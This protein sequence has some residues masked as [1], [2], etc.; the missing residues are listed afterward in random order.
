MKVRVSDYI[1]N[2]LAQ[3]KITQ[4]FTVVGGGSMYLN[5]SFG[6]H[7]ELHCLYNHHEQASAM[8]AEAY[9]RIA[10]VPGVVCVTS[11]PG[12]I[13]A[14]NG[15]AGAYQDSIPLLIFSGQ[16][17]TK[18]LANQSGLNL[19]TMGGQEFDIVSAIGKMTKYAVTVMNAE[20]IRYHLEK[21]LYIAMNGRPGPCWLDIPVD[22]QGTM[23]DSDNLN[24]YTIP[25][26][27]CNNDDVNWNKLID[28]L[29]QAQRPVIYGGNCIRTSG[30][31]KLFREVIDLL[32]IPV[33]LGWN[34]IDLIP[35]QH[36]LYVGRAGIMGDRPGNFAV[37]NSDL[38]LSLGS[39]LGIYQ[40]GYDVKKWARDAY[41]IDVDI[42]KNELAK[43]ILRV[44]M[45][46]CMDIGM[47]MSQL[48]GKLNNIKLE[49]GDWLHQ[50]HLWKQQFPVVQKKQLSQQGL[51]NVYA[52]MDVLGKNLP[53]NTDIVVANGSASVVGSQTLTIKENQRFIMNCAI[54][55]MGYDLPASIGVCMAR[56]KKSVICIAGDGSIQM[57]LQEL[58]TIITNRLPIKIFIVNNQGYHQI[59][60]TERNLFSGHKPI[61]IG[62]ESGD[63]GF[64]EF[65]KLAWAYG[66]RY[67]QCR[68][69]GDLNAFVKD[70]IV[71]EGPVMAEVFVDTNQAFEPKSA[72]K[73]L[74]DGTLV[75]PPL[76]DMAPFLGREELKKQMYIPLTDE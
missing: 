66:Y 70:V 7:S 64:P 22:I 53:E 73:R 74:S 4:I 6:H 56:G 11:G 51:C 8:A 68:T 13:N 50:C 75:S 32:N 42:D 30:N 71:C 26:C 40:V 16:V 54:S 52:F 57:N 48:K 28:K 35:S 3:H 27:E 24:G 41:V 25:P 39:R 29:V 18:L 67:L 63:L 62:P 33:V 58:Q 45:P 60:L 72:T 31:Y 19:R 34:S 1:A 76:E 17:K 69:N 36:P 21:A 43:P 61:G 23:I 15:V 49:K 2:F 47:F 9:S 46:V 5:D 65:K 12:A 44:D 10:P 38:V 20:D 55:S 59:R 37:Q 14:L